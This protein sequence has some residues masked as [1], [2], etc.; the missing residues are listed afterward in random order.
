MQIFI[1]TNSKCLIKF[2]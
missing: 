2:I 1:G